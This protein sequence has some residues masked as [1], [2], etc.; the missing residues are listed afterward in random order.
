MA[1]ALEMQ[2]GQVAFALRGAPAWHNLSNRTFTEDENVSTQEMLDSA[3]LANWNVRLEQVNVP[4]G[5]RNKSEAYYVLRTN[6]FDSGTDVLAVVGERYATYQNEELLTFG[7]NLLAGGGKWESAGSIKDGRVVFASMKIDHDFVVDADGAN[8]AVKSYLLLTTSHD[9][10]SAIRAITTPVRVVCQN[11]LTAALKGAQS[12]Y[13]V[14][15]TSTA[16]AR[17]EDARSA[18]NIAFRHMDEFEKLANE[19]YQSHITTAQ[20]DKIIEALYPTPDKDAS[21]VAH[22]RHIEKTDTIRLIYNNSVTTDTIRG[23]AW[24]AYNALTERVDYFRK[25]RGGGNTENLNAAASGFDTMANQEKQRIL[26]AVR[27]FA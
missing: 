20:F 14:K 4:D 19:L 15:H 22:T 27:A 12:S 18:L 5:Y 16:Q 6:P 8:D 26:D 17:V 13:K 23:T 2:D 25:S 7:D 21:K 11:T 9:G 24:G 10:S 3:M 1:H